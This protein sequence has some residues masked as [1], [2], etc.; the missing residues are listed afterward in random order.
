M[1]FSA[2]ARTVRDVSLPHRRRVSALRSCV[3]L[4]RPLGF[5]ATLS[6][7]G[8]IAGPYD[9]DEAALLRALD[10]LVASRRAWQADVRA[11]A[12]IRRQAKR[13]GRRSPRPVERNPNNGPDHWYGA[14]AGSSPFSE[15]RLAT[16]GGSNDPVSGG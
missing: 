11:Y 8:E 3:Q 12:E 10:A 7:L 9:R 5:H 15:R 13:R 16:T 2:Y 6:Y 1:S 4:Y 14:P